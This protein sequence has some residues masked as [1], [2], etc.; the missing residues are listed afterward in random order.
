MLDRKDTLFFVDEL[1]AVF[2]TLNDK[3]LALCSSIDV[4]DII[5]HRFEMRAGV[6][7]FADEHIVVLAGLQRFI[8]GNWRSHELLFYTSQTIEA[9]L[10]LQVVIG[11]A[12]G[13]RA[14]DGDIIALGTHVVGGADDG[15]V[16]I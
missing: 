10:E 1:L 3:L 13:D 6:V 12:F 15:D 5:R 2:Q 8:N 11:T 16:N 9:R 14:D 4:S 7:G